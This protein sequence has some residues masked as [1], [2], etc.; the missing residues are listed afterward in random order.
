MASS[1]ASGAYWPFAP[2]EVGANRDTQ[3]LKMI[4]MAS[5]LV[6]HAGK[7]FFPQYPVMRIIG[8]LAFPIFAYC[9]A[10]G[11]VYSRNRLKYLT[12]MILTGL[13]SQ[14]FYA[15]ALNHT[16]PKMFAIAFRDN[17]VGAAVNFYVESWQSPNIMLTLTLG[18]LLVWAIRDRQLVCALA[19]ALLTW[20][21]QN[22]VNYGW[23]GVALIGLFY[24]FIGHWWISFPV[25]TAYMAWWG[26][27]GGTYHLF[28]VQFGIQMFAILALPLIYVPMNSG[29]RINKWVFYLFYPGHLMLIML[30]RYVLN[31]G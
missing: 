27:Q 23:R 12:R 10:V 2:R 11:A 20:K 16:T 31:Q 6:D 24:L 9:V 13:I 5:M 7:M 28:G 29:L 14:P 19:V 15:M 8:R 3:L 18:L 17:P 21:I 30:V 26:V 22:S 1:K 4:A 25:L